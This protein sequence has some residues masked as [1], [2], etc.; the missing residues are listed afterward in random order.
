M[1]SLRRRLFAILI[2][3]TGLVWLCG[4]LWLFVGARGELEHVLDARLQEAARMVNSL[5]ARS[6]PPFADATEAANGPEHYERQLSCQIWSLDGHLIARSGSAPDVTLTDKAAGFSDRTIRGE[7]WRVYTIENPAK[8]VRVMIGDRLGQRDQLVADLVKGLLIPALLMLPVLGGLIWLSLGRGLRPLYAMAGQ[9]RCRD[10]DDMRPVDAQNAPCELLP[11]AAAINDLFAK[12]ETARRHEREV[13]AFAAHE[14]RTPLAG[15]KTQAQIALG[16]ADTAVRQGALRQI[17]GS[18]D[19]A[20]RLVRQLLALARLD[21]GQ[22]ADATAQVSVG[23]VLA[24]VVG[25]VAGTGQEV[26]VR[27]DPALQAFTVRANRE[28]LAMALRNLHENAVQHTPP[29]GTVAWTPA[30]DG[31]GVVL[32]DEGPGMPAEELPLAT[33]RFFRGKAQT[34]SGCG[35]GLAIVETVLGRMGGRLV[36]ENRQDRSG[37]R[38]VLVLRR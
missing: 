17:L 5:V 15:L 10:A 38:A 4:I 1:N 13:T 37:L 23:A 9:L 3:A 25:A 19:R 34:P 7:P 22:D 6:G 18:V 33:R 36:L 2:A 26:H 28:S 16:A 12:V 32:E 11:L 31:S 27:V 29:G 30:A 35:L 14:L 20:A 24:E 8:G 21:A